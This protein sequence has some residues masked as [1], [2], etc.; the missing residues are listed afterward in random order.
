M[1]LLK[2]CVINGLTVEKYFFKQP[3][4]AF[5]KTTEACA[6][7]LQKN[8]AHDRECGSEFSCVNG[9]C[10]I[11][12]DV[13]MVGFCR[14][15]HNLMFARNIENFRPWKATNWSQTIPKNY[16]NAIFKKSWFYYQIIL[17][18]NCLLI[19][20]RMKS[21]NLTHWGRVTHICVS[22][23]TIIASDNGLSPDWHQAIIWTNGGILLMRPLWTNF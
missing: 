10:N 20:E 11:T 22:K 21:V 17:G 6:F 18:V 9:R 2:V 15:C 23:L 1:N 14:S 19:K 3:L 4:I 8:C 12:R 16:S 7:F 5:N 13:R